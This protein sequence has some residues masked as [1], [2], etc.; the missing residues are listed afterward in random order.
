MTLVRR[1]RSSVGCGVAQQGRGVAQI[2]VCR[3]AVRKARVRISARH[4]HPMEILLLLSEEAMRIQKDRPRR[5]VKDEWFMMLLCEWFLK[6]IKEWHNATKPFK[7]SVNNS[8]SSK[9]LIKWNSYI[10]TSS[11]WHCRKSSYGF[12]PILLRADISKLLR[13]QVKTW[14]TKNNNDQLILAN[15]QVG[16]MSGEWQSE[17]R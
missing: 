17:P 4:R 8:M 13:S 2:V 9:F 14:A 16:D 12:F 1:R 15:H 3:L 7:K 10:L 11:N 6:I 5:R